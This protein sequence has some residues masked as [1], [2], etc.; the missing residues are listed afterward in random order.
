MKLPRIFRNTHCEFKSLHLTD[1]C[2][3]VF[4]LILMA[5]SAHNLFSHELAMQLSSPLDVVIRTT[6]AAIFGY[7]ISANFQNGGRGDVGAGDAEAAPVRRISA[8]DGGG[9]SAKIGFSAPSESAEA[10][11][12][13]ARV[14]PEETRGCL[15]ILV[16]A[17]TGLTALVL[18]IIAHD[19]FKESAAATATISQLRD[20]VSGSVGFLIG[21]S[22][23]EKSSP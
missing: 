6:A 3:L 9:T 17:A 11:R 13:D 8:L 15:Q 18:L 23:H 16:V 21:H 4:M 22:T 5:Q 7:F 10:G 19:F 1:K 14:T 20:F 12:G 2:L